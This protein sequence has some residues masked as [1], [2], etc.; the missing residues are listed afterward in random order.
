MK[1]F[2]RLILLILLAIGATRLAG[3]ATYTGTV[4]SVSGDVA[5]VSMI[6][7]VMPANGTRAEFFFKIPGIDD[8]IAVGTGSVLRVEQGDLLV[9]IENA[10]GTIE[11]GQSVRFV[12]T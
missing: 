12:S 7:D 11:S 5:T 4:R 8:E 2:P 9:K 10:T 3:A 1:S 6:G